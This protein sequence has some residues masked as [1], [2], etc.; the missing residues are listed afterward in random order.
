MG[1]AEINEVFKLHEG[2]GY[3]LAIRAKGN[4]IPKQGMDHPML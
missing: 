1:E 2:E 4:N 3:V